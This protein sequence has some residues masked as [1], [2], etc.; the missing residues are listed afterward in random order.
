MWRGT[1]HSRNC[2]QQQLLSR[3]QCARS[4][5]RPVPTPINSTDRYAERQLPYAGRS[6]RPTVT[7]I[8]ITKP[9]VPQSWHNCSTFFILQSNW[10]ARLRQAYTQALLSFTHLDNK[11]HV[12]KLNSAHYTVT[13]QAKLVGTGTLPGGCCDTRPSRVIRPTDY[14]LTQIEAFSHGEMYST[15]CVIVYSL[16]GR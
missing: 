5:A 11:T 6:T 4:L 10:L 16:I 12:N 9:T 3:A 2:Q 14:R 8:P 15:I 13:N 7:C 1:L